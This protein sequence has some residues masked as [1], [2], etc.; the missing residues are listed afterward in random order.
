LDIPWESGL[1]DDFPE[2]GIGAVILLHR[3][4]G[5]ANLFGWFDTV[6]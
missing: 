2:D 1:E 5:K 3:K 6:Q 4:N